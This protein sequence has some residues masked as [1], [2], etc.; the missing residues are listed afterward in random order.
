M[1]YNSHQSWTWWASKPLV[2]LACRARGYA[3]IIYYSKLLGH[4]NWWFSTL[5]R[6]VDYHAGFRILDLR[7]Q[8][9][10]SLT[11]Q[12]SCSTSVWINIAVHL[13]VVFSIK[14]WVYTMPKYSV[15]FLNDAHSQECG[16]GYDSCLNCPSI[17]MLCFWK[18]YW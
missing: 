12:P 15:I 17:Y 16:S 14:I 5:C 7:C 3:D 2:T 18:S 11:L 13:N 6:T 4:W 10:Q 8:T 9:V 1:S